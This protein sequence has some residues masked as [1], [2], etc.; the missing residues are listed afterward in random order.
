MIRRW[1]R[2]SSKSSSISP[3]LKN[4]PMKW[5]QEGPLAN[6]LSLLTKTRSKASGPVSV[7][8]STPKTRIR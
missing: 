3:R 8:M 4:G 2:C 6:A 7:Y 1:C 5:D